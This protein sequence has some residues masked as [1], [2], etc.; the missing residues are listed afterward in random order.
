MPGSLEPSGFSKIT[1]TGPPYCCNRHM[2]STTKAISD[3]GEITLR[4][5]AADM[6]RAAV[7]IIIAIL[8]SG[9]TGAAIGHFSDK[10]YDASIIVSPI[11][12][13]SGSNKGALGALAN[14]FSDLASLAGVTPPGAS[15]RSE[16]IAV[17]QSQLLTRNYIQAENLLPLLYA[18]KWDE[19]SKRWRPTDPKK[20]PTSWTA[21]QYFM[22]KIR[23]V[24]DDKVTGLV[25]MKI[26]W[27][28]PLQAAKWANDLV[29]A[30]NVYLRDKSIRESER[31]IAYLTDAGAKTTVIEVKKAIYSLLE[32]EINK[33]MLAQGREEF[34]LRVVDPAFP[35]ERPSSLGTV[36]LTILGLVFGGLMSVIV[37][38]AR[39]VLKYA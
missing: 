6:R 36:S 17:L 25:T 30:T 5:L 34:A 12:Q 11:E 10:E 15:A 28:D 23:R 31:N 19:A 2:E 39:R 29:K 24:T 37:I 35:P 38:F 4:D 33:E 26:R 20:I 27:K 22:K 1:T 3:A 7:P 9:I 14:Q 21:N 32:Q 16:P 18:D 13:D 8:I